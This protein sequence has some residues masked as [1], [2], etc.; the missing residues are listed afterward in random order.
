[1]LAKDFN[2]LPWEVGCIKCP[3]VNRMLCPYA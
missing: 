1:M 2:E 3:N